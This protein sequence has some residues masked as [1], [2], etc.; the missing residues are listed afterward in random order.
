[1]TN[2]VTMTCRVAMTRVARWL[3]VGALMGFIGQRMAALFTR[4]VC[5]SWLGSVCGLPPVRQQRR[6]D[7][8]AAPLQKFS[9]ALALTMPL[10]S[11]SM[12]SRFSI[13]CE[14][15]NR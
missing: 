10:A 4:R 7:R 11:A 1:M 12:L 8:I 15:N 3:Y 9:A 5:S 14:R 13:A 2:V 6:A